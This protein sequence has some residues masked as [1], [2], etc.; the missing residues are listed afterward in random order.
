MTTTTR[1]NTIALIALAALILLLP[2]TAYA[3]AELEAV[4]KALVGFLTGAFGK[5]I[6]TVAV[7]GLAY[8]TFSGRIQMST[9]ITIGAG[10][11]LLFL[12]EPIINWFSSIT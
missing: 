11:V 12:A 3:V 8:L 10:I 9:A 4:A 1:L 2:D 6:A 7:A 5:S